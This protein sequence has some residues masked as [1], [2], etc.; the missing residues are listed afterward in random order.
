MAYLKTGNGLKRWKVNKIIT[1]N[2]ENSIEKEKQMKPREKRLIYLALFVGLIFMFQMAPITSHFYQNY[3][4]SL[5]NLAQKIERYEKLGQ[6]AKYWE[7]EN[8]RA[9]KAHDEIEASL[10]PGENRELMG[11][12]MQGLVKQLAQEA[13][14]TFKSLEPP[15]TSFST[16]EWVLVIQSMQFE[17]TGGTLIEFLKA[18]ENNPAKLE[19]ISLDIRSYR[20]KLSGTIKITGFSRVPPLQN[21]E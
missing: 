3:W 13:G 7:I 12:K 18:V 19:T 10:L 11:A 1:I 8:Q 6:R 2:S 15:D 9:K 14:I 5:E 4:Q 21:E 17:A 20:K 16:G